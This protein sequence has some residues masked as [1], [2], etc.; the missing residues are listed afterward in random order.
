MAVKPTPDGYHS[1]TPYLSIKG[2]AEAIEFYLRAFGA[3]ESF[4]L[5]RGLIS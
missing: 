2:A 4:R 3:T 5:R 1:L